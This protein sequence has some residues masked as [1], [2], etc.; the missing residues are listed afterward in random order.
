MSDDEMSGSEVPGLDEAMI[1][2]L[3]IRTL[4]KFEETSVDRPRIERRNLKRALTVY[5]ECEQV[6]GKAQVGEDIRPLLA[7]MI[8]CQRP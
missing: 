3:P 5:K 4:V 2:S 6:M 7:T 1:Q 8:L